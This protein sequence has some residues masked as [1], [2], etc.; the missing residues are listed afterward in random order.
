[1]GPEAPS[2]QNIGGPRRA[3][4]LRAAEVHGSNRWVPSAN[5]VDADH[6]EGNRAARVPYRERHDSEPSQLLG[7]G[8]SLRPDYRAGAV[9]GR[10]FPMWTLSVGAD[11]YP[12]SVCVS[13]PG[14]E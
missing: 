14:E 10:H 1:M 2:D 7:D 5:A 4:P 8:Q 3:Q 11:G 6:C 12:I 9:S 13:K